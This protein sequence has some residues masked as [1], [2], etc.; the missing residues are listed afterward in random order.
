MMISLQGYAKK[1]RYRLRQ[2][3]ADPNVQPVVRAAAYLLSGFCLSAASLNQLP[4]PLAMALTCACTGWASVFSAIGGIAGYLFFWG[5]AGYQCIWWVSAGLFLALLLGEHRILLQTPLLLPALSGLIVSATGVI[6]QSWFFD[7][8]SVGNYLIRVSLGFATPWLLRCVLSR[9]NPLADWLCCGLGMLAVCQLTPIPGFS[10][11]FMAAGALAVVGTFPAVAVSG[12]AMDLSG[13]SPVPMTAVLCGSYLIRFLPKYPRWLSATAPAVVYFFIST[14]NHAPSTPAL[15][16]MLLGGALG[17]L[18]PAPTQL[19]HRRGETGMAQV[20]LELVSSVLAQTEQLLLEAPQV[21]IDEDVLIARAA[22]E[23]CHS[24]P[25]RKSCKDTIRIAQLPVSVLHKPLVTPEELPIL[26]RKSGRLLAQLHRAQEQL[27]WIEADRQRQQEYRLAVVQQYGFLSE[28]LQ[29]LSDSL[30]RKTDTATAVYAPD[31]HIYA[32]RPVQNNADLC[33]MFPGTRCRYYVVLCDGMGKGPG[34][35]QE[36]KSATELLRRLLSAG[37][38]AR[39]A[40]RSLNSL[41]ALRTRA[42]IVTVE[43]L[44][45]SLETGRATL[46]K[47]GAAPSYL[48]SSYGAE[49]IGTAGP[50]PG[51]SLKDSREATYQLSLR[52]GELLLLVSDGIGQEDALNCCLQN[53]SATPGELAR[54]IL[55]FGQRGGEDDATVVTV[56]LSRRRYEQQ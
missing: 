27:R 31:V 24:C 14:V 30:G 51:L 26:C 50:P 43:L 39:Y 23:A 28:Y 10:L 13:I 45:I 22:E 40:L 20:R 41:C 6:F 17:I 47:W 21:P 19:S 37:Y 34:A 18:L 2:L 8:T 56:S 52:R 3:L 42:G 7:T 55:T 29:E 1:S 32:N 49:K 5:S 38:P 12:L 54:N 15:I 48:L 16:G 44:E 33:I 53:A 11:G 46:Y 9:R 36:A 35:L 4:L 25:C